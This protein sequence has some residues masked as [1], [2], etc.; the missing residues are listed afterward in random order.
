MLLHEDEG[1]VG[2]VGAMNLV[3]AATVVFIFHLLEVLAGMMAQ[4]LMTGP[5]HGIL[6][7]M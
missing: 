2:V 6:Q 7:D 1:V 5:L 4:I 3:A